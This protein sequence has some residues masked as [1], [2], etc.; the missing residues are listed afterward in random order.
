MTHGEDVWFLR[1]IAW[2]GHRSGG[3]S[4]DDTAPDV[5]NATLTAE[6]ASGGSDGTRTE[7]TWAKAIR[8][9][10]QDQSGPRQMAPG[11]P[12]LRAGRDSPKR[13]RRRVQTGHARRSTV[14]R[15]RILRNVSRQDR[16]SR[17]SMGQGENHARRART[18]AQDKNAGS[19]AERARR[20]ARG[21]TARSV[22]IPAGA[23]EDKG[24]RVVQRG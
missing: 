15:V 5:R 14:G 23:R 8:G 10:Q 18:R 9:R 16:A 11:L 12:G 20:G 7:K 4:E 19:E 3:V 24:N 1:R 22:C 21:A 6:E 2:S 17:S 13:S